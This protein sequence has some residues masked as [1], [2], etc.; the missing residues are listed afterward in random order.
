MKIA[1]NIFQLECA[2]R[3]HVFLILC[4]EPTLID[5]GMPKLAD[6]ILKE[7]RSLGVAPK[8]LKTILLTHH[9]VDHVGNAKQLQQATGAALWAPERD[10]PYIR[11]EKKR[12]GVKRLVSA[13]LRPQTP[14]VTG[15]YVNGQRFGGIQAFHTPGHT[16]G[17][18]IFVLDRVV[19]T[20]DLF[21]FIDGRFR[22]FHGYMNW[23]QEEVKKSLAFLK[24]LRF[25]WLCPSHGD[26]VKDGE[27]VKEFLAR[28]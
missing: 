16:P 6:E 10:I 13:A 22:L 9:D 1:E 7:I 23:N 19:F 5:T 28:F 4:D 27:A 25:D 17:H 11:G 12:P 26:P 14:A 3:S 24:T 2:K 18:T 20:G 15:T 8:E 21:K